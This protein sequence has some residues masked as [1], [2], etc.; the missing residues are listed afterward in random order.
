VSVKRTPSEQATT[1]ERI[2]DAMIGHVADH[3]VRSATMDAVARR[4]SLSR[5]TLY[6]YF[7]NKEAILQAAVLRELERFFS[8]LEEVA[9][10]YDDDP[11]QR[12]VETFAH[13]YGELRAHPLVE[14]LVR[15]EPELLALYAARDTPLLAIASQRLAQ[16]DHNPE[17][18]SEQRAEFIVRVLHSLILVSGSSFGLDRPGGAQR[19]AATWLLPALRE[20]WPPDDQSPGG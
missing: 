9:A 17:P 1:R 3:G 15:A 8:E 18:G 19:F 16:M 5:V 20:Q 13:A 6:S 10:R 7:P 12:L 11:E 4:A 2:L 14:R